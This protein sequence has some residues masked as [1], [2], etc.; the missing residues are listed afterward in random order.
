M[1]GPIALKEWAVAV[2]ALLSGRQILLMRKGGIAEETREFTIKSDRFFLYPTYEHQKAHL[3]KPEYRE[4]LKMV[5]P[6]PE[7]VEIRCF[8]ELIEDIEVSSDEQLRRIADHHIWT[9]D[10]ASERLRWKRTK[11]LHVLL[12][13]V[14]ELNEPIRLPVL[15]EYGGCKSW[16]EL[17]TDVD[18]SGMDG[19]RPVL[20]DKEWKEKA[21]S[22]KHLLNMNV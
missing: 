15:P 13:R 21:D 7:T 18:L 19:L 9:D 12:L 20:T 1:P 5:S 10:F 14:Y 22:V 17:K 8:A 6:A 11:P 2:E 4:T 16:I 3:L